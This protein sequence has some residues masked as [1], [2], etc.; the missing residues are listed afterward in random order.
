MRAGSFN[1]ASRGNA[2]ADCATGYTLQFVRSVLPHGAR[3]V[4]EI[5][6]GSGALAAALSLAGLEVTAIDADR[7]AVDFA[8]AR[9]IDAHAAEW[10]AFDASGFDAVLFTR[11][12]HHVA[13]LSG[14]VEAAADALNENGWLIVE[15]FMAEGAPPRSQAWFASLLELLANLGLLASPTPIL[16]EILGSADPEGHDHRLHGSSA[17][18]RALRDCFGTVEIRPAAYHFRYLLPALGE[19]WGAASLA[20][21]LDLIACG[22]IEALG[23]RYVASGRVER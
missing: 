7:S 11:S 22:S 21:E 17:I 10:P 15:D 14:S 13:D 20:H 19:N 1:P 6:C 2:V 8:R 16:T 3:R 4:L 12:L 18:E 9:G 23:R 5:G